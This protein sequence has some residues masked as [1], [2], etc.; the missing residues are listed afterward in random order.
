MLGLDETVSYV[1]LKIKEEEEEEEEAD[2]VLM[3]FC[4]IMSSSLY[5]KMS[6]GKINELGHFVSDFDPEP[7]LEKKKKKSSS[8]LLA[9]FRG[10]DETQVSNWLKHIQ[11]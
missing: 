10:E 2:N 3:F 8:S 7:D 11:L 5:R 9:K 6:L 1:C 4:I